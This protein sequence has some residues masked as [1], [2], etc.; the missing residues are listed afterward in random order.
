[1]ERVSK[2]VQIAP[3]WPAKPE[4]LATRMLMLHPEWEETE[5]AIPVSLILGVSLNNTT[6]LIPISSIGSQFSSV[7]KTV[8]FDDHVW[9]T[10]D[11][12]KPSGGVST[13]SAR[14]GARRTFQ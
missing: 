4:K 9:T 3:P 11:W 7:L 8:V 14:M 13:R 5:I 6:G 1:M 10:L 2:S 12:M